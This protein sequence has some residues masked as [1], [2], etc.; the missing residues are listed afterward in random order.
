MVWYEV[1]TAVS[2]DI[3]GIP[4]FP[5]QAQGAAVYNLI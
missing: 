2:L 5:I 1:L 3:G 4:K